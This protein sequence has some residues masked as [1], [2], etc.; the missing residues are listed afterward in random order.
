MDFIEFLK[1]K[2]GITPPLPDSYGDWLGYEIDSFDAQTSEVCTKLEVRKDHLSPSGAVH[3]GV[4]SGFL[5]FTC[6][7]AVLLAIDK[8][9]SCSTVDLNVKYF[10]PLVEGD[11]VSAKAIVLHKGRSLSSVSAFLYKN[12]DYDKIMAMASGTFNIYSPKVFKT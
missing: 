3:G 6:G 1:K 11:L 8:N 12:G 9:K 2:T 10:Y 5:D 4:I 7:C